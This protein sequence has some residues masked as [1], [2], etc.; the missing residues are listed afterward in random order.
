LRL[1]AKL[2]V[3]MKR[4]LS[5][6]KTLIDRRT[7]K[8]PLP[9]YLLKDLM[10][11]DRDLQRIEKSDGEGVLLRGL[12]L[13][14]YSLFDVYM[15]DLLSAIYK[16]KPDVLDGLNRQFVVS[17]VMKFESFEEFREHILSVEI[18]AFI[19][20]SYIDQFKSL[21][22]RFGIQR[23][24]YKRWSEFV[25]CS[26]RRNITTHCDGIITKQYVET[27]ISEGCKGISIDQVGNPLHIDFDY[28]MNSIE[29][30]M[31]LTMELGQVLWRKM[32]PEE[33]KEANDMLH[34]L[35]FNALEDEDWRRAA[36][37]GE[38]SIQ[39]R[40]KA[41]ETQYLLNLINYAIALS[42]SD[43]QKTAEEVLSL[44]DWSARSPDFRL[45]ACVIK[46]EYVEAGEL[47]KRIG[48]ES[49]YFS[50]SG[51][52]TFPLFRYFVETDEFLKAYEEV[53]KEPFIA[54]VVRV[55]KAELKEVGEY[56]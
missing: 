2:H 55:A 39:K 42:F 43:K 20:D 31:S 19:R 46:K 3:D 24:E 5:E 12:F 49:D 32:F 41:P 6:L 36:C 13:G 1:Q 45:A 29:L 11:K 53:Y 52:H 28:L 23:K 9:P 17:D 22:K 35:V 44:I 4:C 14:I 15:S 25:E 7:D 37:F 47:M 40:N 51:Y 48:K 38:F 50:Q 30:M 27:C 34:K 33:V 10:Q 8:A 16:K 54:E 26:Q 18:D 21:E 56:E